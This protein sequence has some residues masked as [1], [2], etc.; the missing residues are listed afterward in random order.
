MIND[1]ILTESIQLIKAGN[2]DAARSL[3]EPYLLEN[4]NNIQAWLWETELFSNDG[5]KIKVLEACLKQNPGEPQVIKALNF[6]KKRLDSTGSQPATPIS[7]PSPYSYS[8]SPGYPE[9]DVFALRQ[10]ET[11]FSVVEDPQP[12]RSAPPKKAVLPKKPIRISPV[13]MKVILVVLGCI[14]F[15]VAIGFYLGGGYYL[16]GQI[17]QS[18]AVQNCADVVQQTTFVS[19]Y[20]RGLFA[21]MFTG[22]DQYT[23]CRI[24][25]DVEQAVVAKNWEQALSLAQQY[26]AAYP[27][28]PFAKNL[29][30]QAPKYLFTWSAELIASHNY[31]SGIEKLKQILETYPDSPS[32]KPAPE[33]IY[34]TYILWAKE[35]TSK[36]DF[37]EAEPLLKTAL[38]YFKAD[39]ARTEPIKQELV[40]LYV[41][42]GDKQVE[43][44][45]IE[46]GTASYKKAGE[47]SP[48]KIDVELFIAR[49]YLR[50][51]LEISDTNNFD[52]AL[53][54]VKEIS[55]KAQSE[56]I[57]SEA[58]IARE[59]ILS[60]YSSSTSPQATEQL[61]A[62]ITLTCQGQ[63]PELPIFGL[64]IENI[65][66]GSSNA[67]A[68]LPA[69]W[70]AERPGELR[71][72][73][74]SS[75]TEQKIES[76]RY[77][78][79]HYLTRMRYVWQITLYDILTGEVASK[80]SLKGA[81][82]DRCPYR[83]N[84]LVGSTTSRSYGKRPTADQL[85][86]WLTKL[87]I[88]K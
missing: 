46:N 53:A 77:T 45:D 16:N 8:S 61:T 88:A 68:K 69:D 15:I 11:D 67:F 86:A 33:T 85:V 34:Q 41:A 4:P 65:R 17:N 72:V 47:I 62:A 44:G 40:N 3:L 83:A 57:K 73:I 10:A 20:P 49:A 19:L 59:K 50:K 9:S 14:V 18:F 28:G 31:S 63:R 35:L 24:K 32:A 52:K 23:Q 6:F 70:A 87:K 75:E 64:D 78:G 55:D 56:N 1:Y 38:S 42:W 5:D 48:G 80:T 76:C 84:F 27:D 30:E 26:L 58:N 2:K 54:R 21:S 29:S 13:M 82:P 12:L 7:S 22:H 81:D 43:L 25:L 37:K 79:N 39:S 71:Y 51:A 66:F 74:C 36:Q 60:A